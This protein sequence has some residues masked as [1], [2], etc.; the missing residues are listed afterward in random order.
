MS[1][2]EPEL[3]LQKEMFDTQQENDPNA[4]YA[5]SM[6]EDKVRNIL[7]Q[8]NPDALLEDIEHRIRGEKK[9]TYSQEWEKINP[10]SKNKISE[11]LV[12]NF[13][14]YLSAYLTQNNSLSNFSPREIN[15]IMEVVIDYIRDDLSDNAEK[16]GLVKTRIVEEVIPSKEILFETVDGVIK[17]KYKAVNI[18]NRRVLEEVTDYNEFNRI[19]HIICQCTFAV[20]KQ[21]QNGMLAQRIF[22]AL[23]VNETINNQSGKSKM[24]FMRFW[25]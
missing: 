3:R 14:S 16:Y 11:E 12:S 15:N 2:L 24:D 5:D 8:I 17:T 4:I 20:L 6:R 22:K 19:S 13:V 23:R 9:N 18:V 1:E 10:N 21:A 7:G 25:Q